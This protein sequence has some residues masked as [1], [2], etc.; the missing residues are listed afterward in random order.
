MGGVRRS[1]REKATERERRN[2]YREIG[3]KCDWLDV[4]RV[5]VKTLGQ[6]TFE[7]ITDRDQPPSL[8]SR[9]FHLPSNF[10]RAKIEA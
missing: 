10:R 8:R 1:L 2:I 4:K 6:Q 5:R 3:R 9:T 7:P